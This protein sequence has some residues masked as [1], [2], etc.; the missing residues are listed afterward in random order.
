[1]KKYNNYFLTA[2]TI[3]I[4][5]VIFK[6]VLASFFEFNFY[7]L[8]Q[9][10]FA[11]SISSYFL[12][13]AEIIECDF[14]LQRNKYLYVKEKYDVF[15]VEQKECFKKIEK[16]IEFVNIQYENN[17]SIVTDDEHRLLNSFKNSSIKFND[18]YEKSIE[19]EKQLY[20]KSSNKLSKKYFVVMTCAFLILICVLSFE[21]LYKFL[22]QTNSIFCLGA[23]LFVIIAMGVKAKNS[24]T[25]EDFKKITDENIFN[26]KQ[27]IKIMNDIMEKYNYGQAQNADSE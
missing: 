11:I 7:E 27:H 19:G 21:S 10:L 1:M 16:Y 6:A 9:I 26:Q 18:D 3:F 17:A 20:L 22:E 23:F 13:Y 12:S 15:T 4:I 24:K 8:D 25:Y 2:I 5:I 14:D